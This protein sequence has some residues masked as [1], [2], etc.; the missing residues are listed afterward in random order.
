MDSENPSTQSR[1][2]PDYGK[3][4][5]NQQI[6]D[7]LNSKFSELYHPIEHITIDEVIIK[8]RGKLSFSSM[9]KK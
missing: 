9:F 1:E 5:E 6:F 4:W 3:L 7:V 2:D 8:S